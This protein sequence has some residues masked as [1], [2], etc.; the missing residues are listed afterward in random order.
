PGGAVVARGPQHERQIAPGPRRREAR[1]VEDRAVRI[2]P[3]GRG[4]RVAVGGV[5]ERGRLVPL[6]V[7]EAQPAGR[8]AQLAARLVE[9][10]VPDGQQVAVGAGG[11]ARVVVVAR[12]QRAERAGGD[13]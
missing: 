10:T 6:V 3:E 9:A 7:A 2:D 5:P 11:D 13:L 8:L 12:E 1:E 4:V